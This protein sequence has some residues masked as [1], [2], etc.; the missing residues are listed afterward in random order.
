V[1]QAFHACKISENPSN[2]IKISYNVE[3]VTKLLADKTICKERG[4]KNP[5]LILRPSWDFQILNSKF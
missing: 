4:K 1:P 3:Y 5:N 2:S